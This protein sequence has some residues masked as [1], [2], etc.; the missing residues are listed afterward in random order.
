MQRFHKEYKKHREEK[1]GNWISRVRRKH[2]E[3]KEKQ[4]LE[5][6]RHYEICKKIKR[7]PESQKRSVR[8]KWEGMRA[9][10]LVA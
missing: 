6:K 1:L 10:E 3:L 9:P 5:Q 4:N 8:R 7:R 2:L